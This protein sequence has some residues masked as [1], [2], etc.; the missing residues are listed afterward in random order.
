[1]EL[2][3]SI[4]GSV[5][6]RMPLKDALAWMSEALRQNGG[7]HAEAHKALLTAFDAYQRSVA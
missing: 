1:M 3:V 5:R 6:L 4:G 2:T 7:D